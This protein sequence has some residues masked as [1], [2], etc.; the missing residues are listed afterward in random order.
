M[1]LDTS[2]IPNTYLPDTI[3]GATAGATPDERM[4]SL[5]RAMQDI[6]DGLRAATNA[7][8]GGWV[9]MALINGYANTGTPYTIAQYRAAYGRVW[10]RGLV[11][12]GPAGSA[13]FNLPV[14]FRPKYEHG[15]N[16][17]NTAGGSNDVR[18][19]VNGN[20]TPLTSGTAFLDVISFSLD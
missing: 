11:T 5:A 15:F 9:A 12:A 4:M 18:V 20:I 19:Q 2:V 16:C 17:P 1:S 8:S 14:A 3:V 6:L 7:Q 13:C 10:L